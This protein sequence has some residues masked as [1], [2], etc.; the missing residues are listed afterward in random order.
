MPRYSAVPTDDPDPTS[1]KTYTRKVAK[2]VYVFD[3]LRAGIML[4]LTGLNIDATIVSKLRIGV[5]G[6]GSESVVARLGIAMVG[7][8]AGLNRMQKVELGVTIFY[9]SHSEGWL[10][11]L[12]DC[13]R[14]GVADFMCFPFRPIAG[15]QPRPRH[16]HR[17]HA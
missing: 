7:N 13:Y 11:W 2:W 10:V 9:V 12:S 14:I 15:S 3:L 4:G 5:E 16:R 6:E 1:L 8:K 17:C